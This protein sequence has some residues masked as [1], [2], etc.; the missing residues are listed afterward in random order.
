MAA[1]LFTR[2]RKCTGNFAITGLT[3]T[4]AFLAKHPHVAQKVANGLQKALN[5]IR[6][7]REKAL[8][9]LVKRFP[10]IDRSVAKVALDRV[11][12]DNILPHSLQINED[13]WNK[14]IRL[15]LDL[16]DL[17]DPKQFTSYVNNRFAKAAAD[18][19]ASK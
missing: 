7:D 16:G 9:L 5:S 17:K 18:A 15:R 3:V 2:C 4:P 11:I 12:A 14:A 1:Q 6:T 19:H 8:V 13:A 10:E